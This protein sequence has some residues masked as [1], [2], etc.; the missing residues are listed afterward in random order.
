M[1]GGDRPP[2]TRREHEMKV[3]GIRHE[4][5]KSDGTGVTRVFVTY[6]TEHTKEKT[7]MLLYDMFDDSSQFESATEARR[8]RIAGEALSEIVKSYMTLVY[9]GWEG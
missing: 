6:K 8:H 1:S 2:Q 7:A 5:H 4:G 9:Y 3:T